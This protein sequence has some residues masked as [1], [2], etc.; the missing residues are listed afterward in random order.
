MLLLMPLMSAL[1]KATGEVGLVDGD[2]GANSA[3]SQPDTVVDGGSIPANPYSLDN[4]V[5]P[6]PLPQTS[7]SIQPPRLLHTA[8]TG[9]NT[10]TVM[11]S[12]PSMQ[13]ALKFV[14]QGSVLQSWRPH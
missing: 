11:Q 5:P 2:R 8:L 4:L 7:M 10:M 3:N 12:V 1:L 14:R 9:L 6:P 13:F